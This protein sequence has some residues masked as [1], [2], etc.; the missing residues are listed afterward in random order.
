MSIRPYLRG[1]RLHTARNHDHHNNNQNN[2]NKVFL[3]KGLFNH[4][5]DN[6]SDIILVQGYRWPPLC[7]CSGVT[8]HRTFFQAALSCFLWVVLAGAA[9]HPI[10][11]QPEALFLPFGTLPEVS[12]YAKLCGPQYICGKQLRVGLAG[13]RNLRC[14]QLHC[15][16]LSPL[17]SGVLYLQDNAGLQKVWC[18]AGEME[19]AG[20]Q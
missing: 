15:R 5:R 3:Y 16:T 12:E 4:I 19:L 14:N 18:G 13:C 9:A 8:M 17:P 10:A 2:N 6:F 1:G 20:E 11:K 7:L